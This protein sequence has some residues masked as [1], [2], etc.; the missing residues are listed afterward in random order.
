[1]LFLIPNLLLTSPFSVLDVQQSR[2]F[3]SGGDDQM[4]S[5]VKLEKDSKRRFVYSA[6]NC[7][8][9]T[10]STDPDPGSH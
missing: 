8:R 1:M 6:V 4:V 2:E 10:R 3:K 7:S 5:N 9:I